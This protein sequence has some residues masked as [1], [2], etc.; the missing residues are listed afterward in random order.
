MKKRKLTTKLLSCALVFSVTV[1]GLS[2]NTS[3]VPA[4][5]AETTQLTKEDLTEALGSSETSRSRVSVHDPSIV[6]KEGTNEYYVF[7]SHLAVAKTSDLSNW[8]YVYGTENDKKAINLIKNNEFKELVLKLLK[9]NPL[10]IMSEISFDKNNHQSQQ[11]TYYFLI[12]LNHMYSHYRP[13]YY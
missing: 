2:V 1:S 11:D 9:K 5:G 6:Q 7:G 8:E 12:Y 13:Y 4:F 3:T 10:P